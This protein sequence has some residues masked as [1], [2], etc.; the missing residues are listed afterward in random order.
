MK[1][2]IIIL[3]AILLA[4]VLF[5]FVV[6]VVAI[7]TTREGLKEEDTPN[8]AD[9]INNQT[10]KNPEN[11]ESPNTVVTTTVTSGGTFETVTTSTS[12]T[13]NIPAIAA[14][15]VLENA[16][17]NNDDIVLSIDSVGESADGTT[18]VSFRLI[19]AN[20]R[21]AASID[22]SALIK[23]VTADAT[24]TTARIIEG[25]FSNV[26]PGQVIEGK[27]V[28]FLPN[29]RKNVILEIGKDDRI[30]FYEFDFV[31]NLY[32]ATDIGMAPE[33]LA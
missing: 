33:N 18:V 22:P 17:Y 20:A 6:Y 21:Q 2:L 1:K 14:S 10:F 13:E 24:E 4:L 5:L 16:A 29:Y 9:V 32:H 26:A 8:T 31:R 30:F 12:T 7:K 19:T 23:I 11:P 25:N 27:L 28:F 15:I 3:V